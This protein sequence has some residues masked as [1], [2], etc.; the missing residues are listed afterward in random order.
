MINL[1]SCEKKKKLPLAPEASPALKAWERFME[2]SRES[3]TCS[4]GM[5]SCFLI[6]AKIP[7]AYSR[8]SMSA[9]MTSISSYS[10]ITVKGRSRTGSTS[11]PSLDWLIEERG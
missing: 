7:G 3:I 4:A 10:V 6:S 5:P 8:I 2:R 9:R 1:L 11:I